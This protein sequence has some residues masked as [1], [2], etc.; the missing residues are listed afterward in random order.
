MNF[1]KLKKNFGFKIYVF[2][3]YILNCYFF[4]LHVFFMIHIYNLNNINILYK[5]E[6][7]YNMKHDQIL[8]DT[9]NYI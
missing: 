4:V 2:I 8:A 1:G 9:L 7:A 5:L 3:Y 6:H